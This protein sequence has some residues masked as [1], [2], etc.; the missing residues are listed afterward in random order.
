MSSR[1]DIHLSSSIFSLPNTTRRPRAQLLVGT[2]PVPNSLLLT[3]PHRHLVLHRRWVPPRGR[4]PGARARLR[5]SSRPHTIR[6]GGRLPLHATSVHGVRPKRE[7]PLRIGPQDDSDARAGRLRARVH[8]R[9]RP[10]RRR[11]Q[12]LL[13][14]LLLLLAPRLFGVHLRRV[15]E[16]LALDLGLVVHR[17]P[18][19]CRFGGLACL[20]YRA[21]YLTWHLRDD[22]PGAGRVG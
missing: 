21:L 14:L 10:R 1:P 15:P 22:V 18:A 20:G 2:R 11:P 16:Q 5:D 9:E 17:A 12:R 3:S 7:R 8:P 4:L 13:L 19:G 6:P